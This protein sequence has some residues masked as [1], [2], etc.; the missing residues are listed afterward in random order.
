MNRATHLPGLERA[1]HEMPFDQFGRYHMTREAVD[2][3]RQALGQQ[4]LSILDVGGF[5]EDNGKPTLPIKRFLPS[6]DVTV[7]DVVE[8]DLP[9]YMRGDGAALDFDDAHFDLVIS[10]DTLEH[11]PQSRRAAFWRELLRVARHG[12]ILL[13]PFG[14]RE[15]E[16]AETLLYEYIKVELHA[17]HQQLKEHREYVLPRLNDWLQFLQQEGIRAQSYPTGYLHAWLGMMLIKHVLLRIDPGL[18]A[19]HLVDSYY[20][21]SFFAT[22]RRNPAYRHL[23]VAE[24]T[25][26]LVDAVDAALAPTIIHGEDDASTGW[27]AGLLPTL[28]TITQRQLWATQQQ[29]EATQLVQRQETQQYIHQINLHLQQISVLERV[30]ADQQV[31]LNQLQ[32]QLGQL[33]VQVGLAQ[34]QSERYIAAIRDLTERSQWLDGQNTELRR[35]VS[36]MQ[37][38]RIM[39]LLSLVGGR[40]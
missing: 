30:I 39:R 13:A 37:N 27:N 8:C 29:S 7:L 24:K 21:Q 9:G 19:Q 35:Q 36:A 5:Y 23:I 38:G 15:V 34:D 6:D 17:E 40:K 32:Q 2:A 10:A 14:T 22:E 25:A 4:Q 3:C 20:N 18:E 28:L 31:M 12:V 1:M 11:I 26:G 16:S 33:H